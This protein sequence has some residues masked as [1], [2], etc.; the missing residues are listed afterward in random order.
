M[1]AS[2]RHETFFH[3]TGQ[4]PGAS[5]DPI[6]GLRLRPA[7]LARYRDLT[8]LRYDFP[9]V[10]VEAGADA[11]FVHSLSGIVDDM[12][13][14]VAP[15]GIDGEGLRKH[16]LSIE[17]GIRR[18]VAGGASGSLSSLWERAVQE[19]AV[20]KDTGLA[21]YLEEAG[22][23]LGVDG[24]VLDCDAA[25]PR[26]LL[27]HAWR[28]AQ[29][30]KA[31]QRRAEINRLIVK[32]SDALRADFVKSEAGSRP[33][34][35]QASLG[36]RHQ[37]LFD[38]QAMSRLVGRATHGSPLSAARRLRIERVLA[39][40]RSQRFFA[41]PEGNPATRAGAPRTSSSSRRRARCWLRSVSACHR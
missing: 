36:D 30:R 39:T 13:R 24:A 11:G 37:G 10:L 8:R 33:E 19:G 29:A 31:L 34:S 25:M 17:R 22:A 23:S 5:L 38:F 4:R 3:L 6:E 26:R 9:L 15:Q 21:R 2:I 35:L 7:L 14:Q 12:L 20:G 16:V 40:L 41:A 32:L 1:D 27:A 18:L 28:A